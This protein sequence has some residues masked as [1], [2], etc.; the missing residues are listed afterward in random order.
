MEWAIR[1]REND[2]NSLFFRVKIKKKKKK[3]IQLPC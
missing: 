1:L 2:A 3:R